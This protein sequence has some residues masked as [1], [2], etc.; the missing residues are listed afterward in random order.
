MKLLRTIRLDSSD[1]F[2]F[3]RAAEPGEVAVGGSFAFWDDDHAAL[4]GKRSAAFRAGFLGVET[5]GFSTL[6]QICDVDASQVDAAIESL[7]GL[8]TREFGAPDVETARAAAREEVETAQTLAD[9]PAGT[10]IAMRRWR[11]DDGEIREQFRTLHRRAEPEPGGDARH[12]RAFTFFEAEEAEPE[13]VDFDAMIK[14]KL[15]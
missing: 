2:V 5:G 11:A 8:L 1:T 6:A 9:H 12:Y 3:E 4:K 7:A 10:L 15:S 14:G 13:A